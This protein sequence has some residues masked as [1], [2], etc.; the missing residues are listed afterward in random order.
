MMAAPTQVAVSAALNGM[1]AACI[2]A[3][4]TAM[5]YDMAKN[6][7]RPPMISVGTVLPRAEIL[8]NLSTLDQPPSRLL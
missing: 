8:K 1:P 7:V 3:G 5:M 6:V 4:F 2:I